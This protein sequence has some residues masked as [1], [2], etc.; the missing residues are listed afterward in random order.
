MHTF[1]RCQRAQETRSFYFN[2]AIVYSER[3]RGA[4]GSYTHDQLHTC[5]E[6]A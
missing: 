4:Y 2:L 6:L 1:F 5:F 3:F